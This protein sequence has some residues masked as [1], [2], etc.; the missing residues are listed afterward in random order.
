M[1]ARIRSMPS[2]LLRCVMS[3]T[4]SPDDTTRSLP[5]SASIAA[6]PPS[7]APTSTGGRPSWS[8]TATQ[9]AAYAVNE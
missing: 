7:D 8:A 5:P 6:T 3:T 9:S 1:K 4:M 2:G